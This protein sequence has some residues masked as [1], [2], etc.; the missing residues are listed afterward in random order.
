MQTTMLRGNS[1]S[2]ADQA[3]AVGDNPL[4]SPFVT[5]LSSIPFRAF[6]YHPFPSPPRNG[7][8]VQLSGERRK[9]SELSPSRKSI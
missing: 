4:S 2:G 7:H 9:L 8:Q 5:D 1:I 6:S 3:H